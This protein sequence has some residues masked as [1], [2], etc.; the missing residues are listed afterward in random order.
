MFKKTDVP[1]ITTDTVFDG[2]QSMEN[3]SNVFNLN[4]V[5][6]TIMSENSP[7]EYKGSL[8]NQFNENNQQINF[9]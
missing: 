5:N 1:K 7:P 2:L 6:Q 8:R 4:I 9:R 3:I